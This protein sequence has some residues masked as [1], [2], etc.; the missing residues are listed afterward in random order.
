MRAPSGHA[1]RHFQTMRRGSVASCGDVPVMAGI[2]KSAG[3]RV[4]HTVSD[5]PVGAAARPA[6][7]EAEVAP[8]GAGEDEPGDAGCWSDQDPDGDD[9]HG[10]GDWRHRHDIAPA[11]PPWSDGWR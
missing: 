1:A 10:S 5:A 11:C 7:S 8:E 9:A 3:P 2:V 6:D 4:A